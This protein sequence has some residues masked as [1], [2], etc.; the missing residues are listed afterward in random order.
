M[1]DLAIANF[2]PKNATAAAFRDTLVLLRDERAG[3]RQR[4]SDATE[5]HPSLLLTATTAAIRAA[6]Q[7]MKDD[8]LNLRRLDALEGEL[9]RKLAEAE[10]REAADAMAEK[11]CA[12]AAKIEAFNE[13]LATLYAPAAAAIQEGLELEQAAWTAKRG[14]PLDALPEISRAYVGTEA[15][16]LG[17]LVR[18]PGAAGHDPFWWPHLNQ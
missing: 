13:W 1:T 11:I 18:L 6:E 14:L 7:A 8:E 4:L 15:R 16:G 17:F 10:E 5:S 9:S 3:V 2:R 12:A